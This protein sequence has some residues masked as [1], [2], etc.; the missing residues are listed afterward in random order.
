MG[1]VGDGAAEDFVGDGGDVAFAEEEE[2]D[3]VA[4]GVALGPTEVGVRH[5]AG[6]LLQFDRQRGDGVGGAVK[7]REQAWGPMRS[8]VTRSVSVNSEASPRSTSRK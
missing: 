1:G 8:P 5:L 3:Q 6:A 2:A 7:R 4:D